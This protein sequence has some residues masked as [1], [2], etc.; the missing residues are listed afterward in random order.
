MIYRGRGGRRGRDFRFFEKKLGKKLPC[1]AVARL[2]I[3]NSKNSLIGLQP[4]KKAFAELFSKSDNASLRV[5]RISP[6][7]HNLTVSLFID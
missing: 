5:P 6:I 2:D 7:N 4:S 1:W 3:Y